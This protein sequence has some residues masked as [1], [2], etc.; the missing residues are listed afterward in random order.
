MGNSDHVVVSVSISNF[1]SNSN[2]DVLFHHIAY[3]YSLADWDSLRDYLRGVPYDDI[4]K[5]G[6][7]S[8]ASEFS[9]SLLVGIDVYILH[10][11]YQVKS[12]SSP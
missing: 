7:F 5:L 10:R 11:K 4:F 8:A 9:E 6:L 1:P 2:L 12:H 3:G